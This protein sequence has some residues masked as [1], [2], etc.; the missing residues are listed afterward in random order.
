MFFKGCEFSRG[1]GEC[2]RVGG[3]SGIMRKKW[4]GANMM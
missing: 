3:E 2:R 4:G 1:V